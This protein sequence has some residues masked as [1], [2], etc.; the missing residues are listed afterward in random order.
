MA[1]QKPQ[2]Q[3]E[4]HLSHRVAEECAV[5][6]HFLFGLQNDPTF[7]TELRG[8]HFFDKTLGG[9]WD[10]LNGFA[11]DELDTRD[12]AMGADAL[13]MMRGGP[14]GEL[15]Y[16]TVIELISKPDAE[17]P[18]LHNWKYYSNAILETYSKRAAVI[19]AENIQSLAR[20]GGSRSELL[21]AVERLAE[22]LAP[23]ADPNDM[24][25]AEAMI[26]EASD[27]C[28]GPRPLLS[29]GLIGVDR[30]LGGGFWREEFISIGGIE[31]HGKTALAMQLIN[32]WTGN[33]DKGIFISVDMQAQVLGRRALQR[34]SEVNSQDW[35][36]TPQLV[37]EEAFAYANTHAKCFVHD[38]LFDIR[39]ISA[40][41]E[42]RVK[43]DKCRFVVLDFIQAVQ[44]PGRS[45]SDQVREATNRLSNLR[46]KLG[47]TMVLLCQVNKDMKNRKIFWPRNEDLADAAAMRQHSDVILFPVIPYK[48]DKKRLP[49]E[50]EIYITKN[51]NRGTK[52]EL[53]ECRFDGARQLILPSLKDLEEASL[54]SP[55]M[56][57]F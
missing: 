16:R 24:T 52:G 9:I 1:Y 34:H 19:Q 39:N 51:R 30:E 33:G 35:E 40:A 2:R 17:T 38:N 10:Q 45:P 32:Q 25:L 21:E 12:P 27:N 55:S 23:P 11:E 20:Q 14:D 8:E 42:K 44:A 3:L 28:D 46:K 6:L 56:K 18:Y 5:H 4:D 57:N 29:T 54:N 37:I 36:H 41:I 13:R 48:I 43:Q 47:I 50:M 31:S 15:R 7:R 53:V 49:E 22:P 26:R